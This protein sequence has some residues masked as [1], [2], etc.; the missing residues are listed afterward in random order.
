VGEGEA[1]SL[2]ERER[3]GAV[4]TSAARVCHPR[5]N[6]GRQPRRHIVEGFNRQ[7]SSTNMTVDEFADIL[8]DRDARVVHAVF[9]PWE[10]TRAGMV[11]KLRSGLEIAVIGWACRYVGVQNLS[12]GAASA[13]GPRSS[14]A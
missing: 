3:G 14:A 6:Y 5:S 7:V 13:A 2:T 12:S 10:R 4:R 11:L 9:Y 8:R 1:G